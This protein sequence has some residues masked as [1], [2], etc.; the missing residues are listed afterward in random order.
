MNL[1]SILADQDL[2][3]EVRSRIR[4]GAFDPRF[5][6]LDRQVTIET[7]EGV[8]RG[9]TLAVGYDIEA[10]VRVTGRP[11]LI[12]KNGTFSTPESDVWKSRLETSRS[13]I[14][15]AISSV[16]RIELKNHP[17]FEWVGTGWVVKENIVVTNRHVANEFSL[18]DT[19]GSFKF[20]RN[21][22][23][24]EM[25]ARID[26]REEYMQPD[27]VEFRVVKVL[28]I[29]EPEGPDIALL[30]VEFSGVNAPKPIKLANTVNAG[31]YVAAI[32]YPAWDGRRNDPAVMRQVFNDI[33]D[34][35]R[36][37]PGQIVTVTSNYFTHDC[38]TLGGNS[39]SPVIDLSTGEAVGL[40]FAGSYLKEN[41]AV[42]AAIVKDRLNSI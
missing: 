42:P 33:Y 23:N 1:S 24:K 8:A 36:L 9:E 38:S 32:G 41:S 6:I 3:S 15:N 7:L 18:R 39:G 11:A 19:T 31:S 10:I 37:Q 26:L 34:V 28:H 35:K 16:G 12:V 29:E 17:G 13:L 27:E 2:M 14:E 25:G 30:E 40:H 22:E 5:P 20:R 21:Y 4:K